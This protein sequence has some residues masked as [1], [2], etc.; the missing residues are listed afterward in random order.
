[1]RARSNDIGS[2]V[3][4]ILLLSLGVAPVLRHAGEDASRTAPPATPPSV[5]PKEAPAPPLVVKQVGGGEGPSVEVVS[6]ATELPSAAH[7]A[8][9]ALVTLT[10]DEEAL[11]REESV[12]DVATLVARTERAFREADVQ[13]RERMERRYLAALNLAAKLAPPPTPSATD[14]K[15]REVDARYQRALA[16]ERLKWRGLSAE[17]QA[18]AHAEFKEWFFQREESR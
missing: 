17:E 12:D 15:A 18:R 5:P 16:Q 4:G 10:P 13:T 1:M 14:A 9:D 6:A 2:V 11:L 8:R 7:F 3:L